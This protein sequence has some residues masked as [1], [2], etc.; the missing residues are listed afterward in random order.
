MGSPSEQPVRNR[1][2]YRVRPVAGVQFLHDV[3]H[4]ILDRA[5]RYGEYLSDLLVG[6]S[7]CN[8]PQYADLALGEMGNQGIQAKRA[9]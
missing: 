8:Q 2:E 9:W 6:I 7:G 4:V 3:G 1:L 5:A